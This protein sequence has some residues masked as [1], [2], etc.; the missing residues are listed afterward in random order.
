VDLDASRSSNVA[1]RLDKDDDSNHGIERRSPREISTENLSL[2][3]GVRRPR[4]IDGS[5]HL[6]GART[7]HLH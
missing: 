6:R 7:G 4:V 5:G 3:V 2:P 1:R